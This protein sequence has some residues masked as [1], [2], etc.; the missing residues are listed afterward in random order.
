MFSVFLCSVWLLLVIVLSSNHNYYI[1]STVIEDILVCSF[2][3]R[4]HV[5]ISCI[6]FF[7]LMEAEEAPGL[8]NLYFLVLSRSGGE[9]ST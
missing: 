1:S 4:R 9:G 6:K 5:D 8:D 3:C 7:Y 2:F